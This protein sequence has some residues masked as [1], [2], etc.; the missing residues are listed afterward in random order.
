MR[1][2]AVFVQ[3]A[4]MYPKGSKR[5]PDVASVCEDNVD[6]KA[7]AEKKREMDEEYAPS[8]SGLH[9]WIVPRIR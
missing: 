2:H 8:L 6:W 5:L 1:M 7:A 3:C 9:S 4:P